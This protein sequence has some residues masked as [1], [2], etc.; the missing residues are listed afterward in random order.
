MQTNCP[1]CNAKL[2]LH[3]GYGVCNDCGEIVAFDIEEEIEEITEEETVEEIIEEASE[4]LPADIETE[5]IIKEAAENTEEAKEIEEAEEIIEKVIEETDETEE[6][7]EII[8]PQML[9]VQDAPKRS[10]APIVIFVVLLL[11]AVIFA[12]WYFVPHFIPKDN[13]IVSEEA[14]IPE[15]VEEFEIVEEL[16]ETTETESPEIPEEREVKTVAE[17]D[18]AVKKAEEAPERI[19]APQISYRIRKSADDSK[20]QIGAFSDLERAKAFAIAHSEDGYKVFD[21]SG[22]V[23]FEP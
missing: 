3:E 17:P 23:I 11:C 9:E 14:D 4:E 7:E 16:P 13:E 22:N 6:A 2:L 8:A 20:T 5:E 10:K 21:M 1:K 18:A 19:E 15:I 12:A